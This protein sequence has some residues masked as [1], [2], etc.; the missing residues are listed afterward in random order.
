MIRQKAEQL[1]TPGSF[2]I[3]DMNENKN[4]TCYNIMYILYHADQE[5]FLRYCRE[6]DCDKM[7]A[8]RISQIVEAF[9]KGNN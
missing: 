4:Y 8:Y 1:Y 3:E 9:D 5:K 7:A 6:L 2:P